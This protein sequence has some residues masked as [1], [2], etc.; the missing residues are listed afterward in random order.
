MYYIPQLQFHTL[1]P[2]TET[3]AVMSGAESYQSLKPSLQDCWAEINTLLRAGE[4]EIEPGI[5]VPV[6]IF[7]GGDYKVR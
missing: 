5:A 4:V 1:F 7:L 3:I 2:D 6:E